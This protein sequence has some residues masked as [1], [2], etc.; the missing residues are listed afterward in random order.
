MKWSTPPAPRVFSTA[1]SRHLSA[2]KSMPARNWWPNS[3]VHWSHNAMAW[4]SIS[5]KTVAHTSK[6]GSMNWRNRHSL[7]RRRFWTWKG[8][9]QSLLKR[10]IRLHRSWNKMLL[11]SKRTNTRPRN[12]SF[13]HRWLI[14]NPPM[15][16]RNW[17]NWRTKATTRDCWHSPRS[18]TTATVWTS[19][20]HSLLP[21]RTGEMIC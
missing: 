4:P 18:I 2:R 6:G 20:I 8:L 15:T 5:R 7:S 21:S 14:S 9:R 12:V 17:T 13:T 1:S 19:S 10:W 11:K 16:R 3:A